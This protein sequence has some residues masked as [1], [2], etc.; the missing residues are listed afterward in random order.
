MAVKDTPRPLGDFRAMLTTPWSLW[1]SCGPHQRKVMDRPRFGDDSG[2]NLSLHFQ[3]FAAGVEL[4]QE[5]CSACVT[6]VPLLGRH[7]FM[8]TSV[9]F[10]GV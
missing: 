7:V 6:P 5:Q 9:K 8:K 3:K 1:G 4:K 2:K 10:V